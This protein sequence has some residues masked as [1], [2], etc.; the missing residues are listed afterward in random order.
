MEFPAY[1]PMT[2]KYVG[3]RKLPVV[4]NTPIP[5]LAHS[6]KQGELS[7][8][9]TA[10][11]PNAEWVKFLLEECGE[12]FAQDVP[13]TSVVK[14]VESNASETA[15]VMPFVQTTDQKMENSYL[16]KQFMGKAGK[17]NAIA[18]LRKRHL[19]KSLGIHRIDGGWELVAVTAAE[20]EGV[21]DRQP[22]TV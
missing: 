4:L 19:E 3:H 11:V 20:A 2:I 9:P 10:Y 7:F 1:R 17:W 12:A 22:V 16:G 6:D 15:A 13:L 5:F 18:F 21:P 14:A 8:N